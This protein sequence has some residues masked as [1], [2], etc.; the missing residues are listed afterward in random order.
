[1]HCTKSQFVSAYNK[2]YPDDF[3]REA[4]ELLYDHLTSLE[5]DWDNLEFGTINDNYVEQPLKECVIDFD[6]ESEVDLEDLEDESKEASEEV[7]QEILK[8]YLKDR[9]DLVGFTP[10]GVVYAFNFE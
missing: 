8:A 2:E 1:M 9:T 7:L 3:S 4:L 5:I 10:Q 6:L